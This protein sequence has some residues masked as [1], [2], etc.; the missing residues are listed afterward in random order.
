MKHRFSAALAAAVW[1]FAA[2]AV[3]DGLKAVGPETESVSRTWAES[4]FFA[5]MQEVTGVTVEGREEPDGAKWQKMLDGMEKGETDADILFKA[6]LTRSR[7]QRL[8]DAGALIDLAPLIDDEM[9]N[10]SRLLSLHPEWRKIIELPDGRIA[11][12]PQ[13]NTE[14]RQVCAWINAAWLEKLGLPVPE[15]TEA[16]TRTLAAF[17]EDDPNGNGLK[18]EIAADITGVWEMRWLLPYFGIVADDWNIARLDDGSLTFAP[19]LPQYRA[20]VE[21]LAEWREKGLLPETAF[22]DLYAAKALEDSTASS[23]QSRQEQTVSGLI[24]S[25][26][27]LTRAPVG[28]VMDYTALLIPSNGKRMWRDLLGPVWTG[29]FAVTSACRDVSAALRWVDALYGEEAAVL[30][31]AGIEK[32]DWIRNA[33]G[34]WRFLTSDARTIETIRRESLM[35]TGTTI[36]GLYPAAF[37]SGVDSAQDRWIAGESARVN[38][39][40]ILVNAPYTLSGKALERAETLNRELAR[41]VDEG[42]G[43]F[44]SGEQPLDDAHWQAFLDELHRAG[45]GELLELFNAAQ[46]VQ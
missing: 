21:M 26:S 12:L 15:S 22:T 37:M 2:S 6:E 1:L 33:D 29:C 43:R 24:V 10:L 36:P 46:S 42:I 11:S 14:E 19:D 13:I 27:P 20:F 3:A 30:A 25:A 45:S 40:S 18:D 4:R 17:A 8:M 44:A 31:C 9:P 7:E 32:E 28:S 34:T 35:N 41:L 39:I 5:R 38:E 16:L 23:R